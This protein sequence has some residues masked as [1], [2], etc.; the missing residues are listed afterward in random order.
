MRM[1]IYSRFSSVH[2]ILLACDVS[3]YEIG[4]VLSHNFVNGSEKPIG[5]MSFKNINRY[6][7]RDTHK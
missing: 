7:C 5:F 3:A 2:P 1:P 4:A 6:I